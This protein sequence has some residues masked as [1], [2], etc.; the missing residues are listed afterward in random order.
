MVEV[1]GVVHAQTNWMGALHWRSF[2]EVSST[3]SMNVKCT[4]SNSDCI[5]QKSWQIQ[6]N[7]PRAHIGMEVRYLLAFRLAAYLK[8]AVSIHYWILL[9]LVLGSIIYCIT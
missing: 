6:C 1:A 4:Y 5:L 9:C 3:K 7:L 8:T 2:K